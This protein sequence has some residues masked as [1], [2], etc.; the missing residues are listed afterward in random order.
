VFANSAIAN[1]APA[2]KKSQ[3]QLKYHNT[4]AYMGTRV[5]L[6]P[7]AL[8]AQLPED[9]LVGQGILVTG[10]TKDSPAEKAGIKAYDILLT[11]D[12]HAL[13]HPKNFIDLI[14]NDQIGREVKLKL[15]RKGK[16]ITI[17]VTL[18]SQQYD[19]DADQLDYQYNIQLK[20][21]DGIQINQ[22]S[23]NN[24]KAMIRYLAPDNVVKV[25]TFTGA[26]KKVLYDI[27]MAPDMSQIAKHDLT[28]E[29]TKRKD[30]EDGWFGK[31]IPFGDG[32][33]SPSNMKNF[34]LPK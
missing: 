8:A 31:W 10:F 25:R 19:L 5:D 15:V 2:V 12:R 20:G 24:F 29:I 30:D 18:T 27:Q 17:P 26:Y 22:L 14:R 1:N 28:R 34:G 6:L 21:Y 16:I 9:V 33:F 23:K 7:P 11:Y 32:N 3:K 4:A 13:M